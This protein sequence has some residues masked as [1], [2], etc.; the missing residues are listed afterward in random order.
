M[1]TKNVFLML[2][3][4]WATG[5]ARLTKKAADIYLLDSLPKRETPLKEDVS[6]KFEL[7]VTAPEIESSQ[8]EL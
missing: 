6:K 2:C 8:S 7:K 4:N 1:Q 3:M 5:E